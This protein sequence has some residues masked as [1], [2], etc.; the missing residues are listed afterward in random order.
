VVPLPPGI[1]LAAFRIVQEAL[2][3]ARRHAPG[4]NVDVE[5]TYG[6][7]TV[8]LRIRD[9]GPGPADELLAGHGIVGMRDRATI[10]SGAF[11]C[12]AADGGGFVVDV[13]LPTAEPTA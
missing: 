1:D 8:R 11:Q 10:A 6:E 2:T 9:Y 7:G 4:A 13:E 3:N 5:V 12:G